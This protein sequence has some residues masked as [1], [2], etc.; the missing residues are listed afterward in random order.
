MLY[1]IKA[2]KGVKKILKKIDTIQ[3]NVTKTVNG[4][5]TDCKK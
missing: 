5:E 1:L 3:T 2:N 4:L